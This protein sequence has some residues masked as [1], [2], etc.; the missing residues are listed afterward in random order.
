MFRP[1][2]AVLMLCELGLKRLNLRLP[3]CSNLLRIDFHPGHFMLRLW[4]RLVIFKTQVAKILKKLFCNQDGFFTT[5]S[6]DNFI[7]LPVGKF[8]ARYNNLPLMFFRYAVI[9]ESCR[10]HKQFFSKLIRLIRG[11]LKYLCFYYTIR[12]SQKMRK[13][14]KNQLSPN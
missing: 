11:L 1:S 10:V 14:K 9:H 2:M 4:S 5:V 6:A 8:L 3:I 12:C 7:N 13:T